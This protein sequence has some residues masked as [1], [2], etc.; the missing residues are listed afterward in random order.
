MTSLGKLVFVDLHESK[1]DK[2]MNEDDER[3]SLAYENLEDLPYNLIECFAGFAKT[4]DL[5][6]NR[7]MNV[8][9]LS[10]FTG[11]TAIILDHNLISSNTV[12][13]YL[14]NVTL[15]WL[16]HN[17]IK[18]L[19]PFIRKLRTSFPE[20]RYLSLMGNE[21]APSYLNG[22]SV[23]EYFQYRLF[24]ISW[25][26]HLIHLDDC[27][28]T[29]EQREEAKRL[30]HRSFFDKFPLSSMS[31]TS[32]NS[33]NGIPSYIRAIHSK[34]VDTFIQWDRRHTKPIAN[35]QGSDNE[36]QSNAII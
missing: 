25:F 14:P 35:H 18:Q 32:E 10:R 19:H 31:F 16:N 7:F 20:L 29:N 15:V 12:F 23:Y 27:V 8:D 34:L 4:L 11:L 36:S 9:F 33:A 3:L 6:H 28:V 26:P 2:F 17:K 21:A 30:Y 24:V 13:P 1:G 5:S 22:G